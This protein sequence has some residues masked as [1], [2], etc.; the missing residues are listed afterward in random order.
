MRQPV[1]VALHAS[2]AR[3]MGERGE[4]VELGRAVERDDDVESVRTAGLHPALEPSSPSRSRTCSCGSIP[5]A[6]PS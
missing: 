4:L 5:G 2:R 1:G 3:A 6:T